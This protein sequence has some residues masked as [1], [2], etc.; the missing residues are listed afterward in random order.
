MYT[1]T[2]DGITYDLADAIKQIDG[3]DAGLSAYQTGSISGTTWID[4]NY[5]GILSK[6]E[7]A[8]NGAGIMLDR[9]YYDPASKSWISDHWMVQS[10]MQ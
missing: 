10:I 4:A 9:A 8:L 1:A 3:N 7:E 6:D 5:D 2:V